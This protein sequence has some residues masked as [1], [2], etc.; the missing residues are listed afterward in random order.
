MDSLLSTLLEGA[1][2]AAAAAEEQGPQGEQ[3]RA[4]GAEE[5]VSLGHRIRTGQ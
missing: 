4:C 3:V 5:V 1:S 2:A